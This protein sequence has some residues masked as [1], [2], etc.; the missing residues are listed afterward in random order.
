M[1]PK[2]R[3]ICRTALILALCVAAQFLKNVSVYI[4]GPI[5]NALL[6]LGTLSC[7]LWSGAALSILTPLTSWLI[8]ASPVMS[9]FPLI[10]PCIMLGNL[11]LSVFVWLLGVRVAR[12]QPESEPLSLRDTRYRSGL[13]VALVA[14][15]LWGGICVAFFVS[16]GELLQVSVT[17]MVLIVLFGVAGSFAIFAGLWTLAAKLPKSWLLITGLTIGSLAKALFMWLTISR[18]ILTMET[19]LPD[20]V[21]S[22]AKMTFSVTQLLTALLG[23]LLAFVIYLPLRKFLERRQDK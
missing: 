14:A 17:A 3:L 11:L 10:V 15:L 9:A 5:I 1:N 16:F 2:I 22:V 4:T 13:T 21:V 18:G 23:S 20:A 12:G 19:N 8:T 7:G 6:I